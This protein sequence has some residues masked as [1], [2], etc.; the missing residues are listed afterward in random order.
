M[1]KK[2]VLSFFF[3]IL[4][5]LMSSSSWAA[6]REKSVEEWAEEFI[7]PHMDER[8]ADGIRAAI[9]GIDPAQRADILDN[10]RPFVR[11]EMHEGIIISII[12]IMQRVPQAQRQAFVQNVQEILRQDEAEGKIPQVVLTFERV[13]SRD[14]RDPAEVEREHRVGER[15]R[16]HNRQGNERLRA[17]L[18]RERRRPN[19][20]KRERNWPHEE[21]GKNPKARKH[22]DPE[23]EA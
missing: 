12:R 1:N 11:P 22:R 5:L 13:W 10:I 23:D 4:T 8:G 7:N 6:A 21:L 20:R 3:L 17:E 15:L 19:F 16:Q 9:R 18:H 2:T 14:F